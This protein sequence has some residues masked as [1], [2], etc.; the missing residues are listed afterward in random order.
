M[1]LRRVSNAAK[2]SRKLAAAL[3]LLFA[4]AAG[5]DA[6]ATQP[7]RYTLARCR[8]IALYIEDEYYVSMLE[9]NEQHFGPDRRRVTMDRIHAKRSAALGKLEQKCNEAIYDR[10]IAEEVARKHMARKKKPE[11]K[12]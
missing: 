6:L 2:N 1:R 11:E 12:Q 8:R 3:F 7:I 4:G 10:T 5:L 9:M